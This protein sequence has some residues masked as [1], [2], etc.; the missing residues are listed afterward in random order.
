[1]DQILLPE[2]DSHDFHE[3][4]V[5]RKG[6]DTISSH[7]GPLPA[8]ANSKAYETMNFFGVVSRSLTASPRCVAEILK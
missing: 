8:D 2:R 1:M 4:K 6:D 3:F 5:Y 7:R